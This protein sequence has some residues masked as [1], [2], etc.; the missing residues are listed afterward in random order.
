MGQQLCLLKIY[1][2]ME[3]NYKTLSQ[4]SELEFIYYSGIRCE[5]PFN[6]QRH[7]LWQRLRFR[8][9]QPE[10]VKCRWRVAG[11][12]SQVANSQKGFRLLTDEAECCCRREIV[13]CVIKVVDEKF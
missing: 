2:I 6:T 13:P 10:G 9:I 12:G 4:Q 5:S 11:G 3:G 1:I 7:C 8:M